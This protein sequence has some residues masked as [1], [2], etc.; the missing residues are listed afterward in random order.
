MAPK[1]SG[2]DSPPDSRLAQRR[3]NRR[4]GIGRKSDE[5]WQAILAGAA[6]VFSRLGYATATL[7]EGI[8][9]GEFRADLDAQ[10]TM[11]GIIGMCNWTHRWWK[12]STGRSLPEIGDYFTALVLDGVTAPAASSRSRRAAG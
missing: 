9:T 7:E 12:P 1:S 10:L 6:Q 3:T 2:P 8:E 11:R 5:R 4:G